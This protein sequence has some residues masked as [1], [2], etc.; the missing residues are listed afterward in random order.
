MKKQSGGATGFRRGWLVILLLSLAFILPA[1]SAEA[2]QRGGILGTGFESRGDMHQTGFDKG[3]S[4]SEFASRVDGRMAELQGERT[5]GAPRPASSIEE[6]AKVEKARVRLEAGYGRFP[7]LFEENGG[8]T[9]PEVAFTVKGSDKTLYFTP[10][11]LTF[12][13]TMPKET[14]GGTSES[15]NPESRRISSR[16]KGRERPGEESRERWTLKLDFVDAGRVRPE[17]E[18]PAETVISY[19]KGPES[20]HRSGVPT[21]NSI[22]YS[23]L[24]PGIDLVYDGDASHLKYRFVVRPGTDPERIRLA[25]RGAERLNVNGDGGLEIVTAAG[26]LRDDAP[27]S[28][29]E[30]EEG[31]V[32]VNVSYSLGRSEIESCALDAPLDYGFSV[33]GYD[34]AREL[35]I[36]P[37]VLVYCGFIGGS[38][39]DGGTA[40]AVDG[41]GN[42]YVTGWTESDERTFPVA[43]GPDLEYKGSGDAFVAKVNAAGT[44][45]VYCGYIGGSESDFG[46]GIAVDGARYVYVTGG[47]FSD[48]RSFPAVVGPDLTHNGGLD[49]FVAK[50]NAAGTG[51]VYC[52][53]IG[54]ENWDFGEG[55]AVD[56]SGN[57]YVTGY[58]EY[59]ETTFPVTVGPDMTHN[60]GGDAFV[61][62]VNAAGTGLVYCGYIGGSGRDAGGG[63]AVDGGGNAYVTGWTE[64]DK[65][66]FPV[67]LG[68]ALTHNGKRDAFVAK[69]NAA[70]TGLVYC[71]YIGG[72]KDDEGLSIAVDGS[73]NAYVTGWTESDETTFPVAVGPDLTQNGDWDAFVAKVNVAGTE[74][75]YC[76]YI[77]G[78]DPDS[79][80]G[81]AVDAWSNVYVTGWTHS[82]ERTFPVTIGPDLTFNG[83][84]DAFVAKV[85]AAGSEL[86]YCGYIGGERDDGGEGV[87]VDGLGNAYVTG[88]ANSNLWDDEGDSIA[89]DESDN[90]YVTGRTGSD[91]TSFPVTVGP[92]LTC[93]GEGDAFVAKIGAVV[94]PPDAARMSDEDFRKL[95]AEGTAAEVRA[96]I[97]AGATVKGKKGEPT[98][99]HWAGLNPK[100]GVISALLKAG[101]DVNARSKDGTTPLHIAAANNSAAEAVSLLLKAGA[102]ANTRN[103]DGRTPLHSC[104]YGEAAAP[105]VEALLKA[106]ADANA[107]DAEGVTPL[108]FTVADASKRSVTAL[109]LRS[110]ADA[111]AKD[112]DGGTP[113]HRAAASNT[114]PDVVPLLLKSGAKANARDKDGRTPLHLAAR[115][116]PNPVVTELLLKAGADAKA[117]DASGMRPIDYAEKN[118]SLRGTEANWK[119]NDAGY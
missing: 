23:D 109:L 26:V 50:V 16:L 80:K 87:A 96:A 47:T 64:S 72:R 6:T 35:I 106:G 68:P 38:G 89:E 60:G 2:F 69:V 98:P 43:V 119:L 48:E 103:R 11:G 71:G 57:A 107:R 61:A 58:T 18:K 19:F 100:P 49:A 62:K 118:R 31:R 110:G 74:L 13:L 70:G 7:L 85:D 101:A 20:E 29:Q 94:P 59:G 54:G 104:A 82:D 24:W 99:L 66:T 17:G 65:R 102:N 37:V 8:Q 33:D 112:R 14:E 81:I 56:G 30:T 5:R 53:Y 41:N 116:N 86:L 108:F 51:L 105:V 44:E 15:E 34:P 55:I 92:D 97:E 45:L 75:V 115:S 84:W 111:N 52:G 77:G 12:S 21:Y 83:R 22:V 114:D 93:N 4:I 32:P 27:V 36:D 28:W 88:L 76:G 63:I 113:L 117:K 3:S 40:I 46:Y 90:A 39:E 95:C 78:S 10:E 42:V 9:S 91:E 25:Y 67:K 79:G 73:G 1:L